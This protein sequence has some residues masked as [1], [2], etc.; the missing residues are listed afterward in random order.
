MIL[1]TPDEHVPPERP[2]PEAF[3]VLRERLRAA[4]PFYG[5]RNT[6]P[7]C[8]HGRWADEWCQDCEAQRGG[9]A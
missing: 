3:R 7:P 2:M 4:A 5:P 9:G 1:P 8:E 6:T